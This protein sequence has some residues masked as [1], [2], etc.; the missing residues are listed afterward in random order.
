MLTKQKLDLFKVVGGDVPLTKPLTVM[1]RTI[2]AILSVDA[3][4]KIKPKKET[5]SDSPSHHHPPPNTPKT[6]T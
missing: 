5:P 6:T 4:L 2:Q 1:V 3:I